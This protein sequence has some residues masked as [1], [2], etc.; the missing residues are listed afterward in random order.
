MAKAKA[1][2]SKAIEDI[3]TMDEA[4]LIAA[5]RILAKRAKA[6]KDAAGKPGLQPVALA[7][8]DPG[9]NVVARC[10]F[11]T[12][13]E[14]TV[15]GVIRMADADGSAKI[16]VSPSRSAWSA[17]ITVT[18]GE[19]GDLSALCALVAEHAP[20]IEAYLRKE[21]A[22]LAKAHRFIA[23]AKPAAE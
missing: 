16:T 2:A 1:K 10:R 12:P 11:N 6:A 4:T 14:R 22:R 8:A 18:G 17:G 15:W 3:D 13:G 21:Y 20:A 5:Q 19:P 23:K 9:N 7:P